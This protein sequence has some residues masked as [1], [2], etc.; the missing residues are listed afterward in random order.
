MSGLDALGWIATALVAISYFT[1]RPATLRRVQAL[2]ACLWLV[3]GV[4]IHAQPVIVAN[5]FVIVAA[6]ASSFRPAPQEAAR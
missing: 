6:L 5:V 3:Y 4:L 2:G 1:R